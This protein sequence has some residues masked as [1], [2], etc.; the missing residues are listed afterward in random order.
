[1]AEQLGTIAL[2]GNAAEFL[3]GTGVFSTP[4]GG[5][6]TPVSLVTTDF[7]TAARFSTAVV[8]AGTTAFSDA[9][10][11]LSTTAT[12]TSSSQ[13]RWTPKSNQANGT[14]LLGSPTVSMSILPPTTP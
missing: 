5:S 9:G 10:V 4:A 8:N 6:S 1:M 11:L 2:S 13:I 3:D 12:T 7:E 14:T